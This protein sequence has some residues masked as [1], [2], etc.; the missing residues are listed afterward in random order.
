[1]LVEDVDDVAGRVGNAADRPPGTSMTSPT[2]LM[3]GCCL[4]KAT[5]TSTW[6]NAPEVHRSLSSG[7]VSSMSCTGEPGSS[8]ATGGLA[9]APGLIQ[10]EL[11]AVE[12]ECRG[13]ILHRLVDECQLHARN[14]T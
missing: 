3:S 6:K 1:L 9:L 13:E 10:T 11:V 2:H 8:N 5:T 12:N 4:V 14:I 7:R